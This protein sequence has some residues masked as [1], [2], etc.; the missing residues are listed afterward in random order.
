M[1]P[2]LREYVERLFLSAPKTHQAY[3]LKEEIIKNTIE[4]YHDL[5]AEGKS[6]VE[7]YELAIRGIGDI[8]ELIEALGGEV[9][10]TPVYTDEEFYQI[11]NRMSVFEAIAV[12]LYILCFIPCI[13]LAEIPFLGEIS[14]AF[15]FFMISTATGLLIYGKKTK[16]LVCEKDMAKASAIKKKAL[17]KATAVGMYI[18]CVTPCILLAST[19]IVEISPVF[20]FMMIALATVIIVLSKDSNHYTKADDT[21]VEN[22][23]EFNGRK[24]H[25]SAL[26]KFLVAILWITTSIVY[27]YL[28]IATGLITVVVTWIIFLVAVAVQNLMKAIFDYVEAK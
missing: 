28:T 1:E 15:M 8:N 21:M 6:E 26:Y 13:L 17:M 23:K 7:A 25:T 2:K 10:E 12:A 3:E 27:V 22:F 18:S 9:K 19:P 4:R 14:P 5:V 20:M 24:K 11:K 16:Y